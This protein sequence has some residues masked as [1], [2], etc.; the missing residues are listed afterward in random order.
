MFGQVDPLHLTISWAGHW[1][2]TLLEQ[3]TELRAGVKT[4]LGLGGGKLFL[5]K[6]WE[7]SVDDSVTF[8]GSSQ[9]NFEFKENLEATS[10]SPVLV[11]G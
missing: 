3:Q 5:F 9:D 10:A 4:C 7:I 2:F 8:V 1:V 6:G 11:R